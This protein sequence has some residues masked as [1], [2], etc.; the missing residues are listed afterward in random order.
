MLYR[1]TFLLFAP[2]LVVTRTGC[3]PNSFEGC[4]L[5]MCSHDYIVGS[6]GIPPLRKGEGQNRRFLSVHDDTRQGIEPLISVARTE[7]D[8][9]LRNYMRSVGSP[10]SLKI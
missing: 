3:P 9:I 8:I 10:P 2:T 5:Q 4:H 7:S 6:S 1:G